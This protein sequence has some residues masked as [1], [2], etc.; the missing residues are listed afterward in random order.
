MDKLAK[1]Y[2]K[3][4]ARNYLPLMSADELLVEGIQLSDTQYAWLN[5]F[6]ERWE[7]SC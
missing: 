3:W 2:R 1:E 6:I 5:G 7:K 4:C